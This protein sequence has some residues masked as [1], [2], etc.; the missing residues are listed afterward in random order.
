MVLSTCLKSEVG[1]PSVATI[2]SSF[3]L[4]SSPVSSDASS[5]ASPAVD[6]AGSDLNPANPLPILIRATNGK[7]RENRARKIKLSTLVE[8]DALD[9]FYARYAELCKNGMT[10]LKPRDRSKKKAKARSKKKGAAATS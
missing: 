5:S 3:S 1:R 4:T 8:P 7:S 6:A 2:L 10:A 9:T